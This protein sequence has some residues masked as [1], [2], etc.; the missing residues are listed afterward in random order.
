MKT[1]R[2]VKYEISQYAPITMSCKSYSVL[3]DV[4]IKMHWNGPKLDVSYIEMN[5]LIE[6]NF[7]KRFFFWVKKTND[8]IEEDYIFLK[9]V[10]VVVSDYY[11]KYYIFYK[12]DCTE[13]ERR[14][15]KLRNLG[16]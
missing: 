13:E 15:N 8:S 5:E 11:E 4:G 9:S 1:I 2:N 7:D 6:Q 16:I 14:N 12:E 3:I 10:D